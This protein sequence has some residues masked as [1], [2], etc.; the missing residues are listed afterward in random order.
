MGMRR[1]G[2]V[3]NGVQTLQRNLSATD[4]AWHDT[5]GMRAACLIQSYPVPT[6]GPA[7]PEHP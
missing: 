3:T 2:R 1:D 5:T 7:A 6:G 4:A